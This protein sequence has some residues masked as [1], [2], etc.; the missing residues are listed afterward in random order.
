MNGLLMQ[1]ENRASNMPMGGVPMA[2]MQLKSK[3]GSLLE[4]RSV[5]AFEFW[6]CRSRKQTSKR[7]DHTEARTDAAGLILSRDRRKITDGDSRET[8]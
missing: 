2:M 8:A 5:L 1:F 3:M 7:E 6:R 4:S